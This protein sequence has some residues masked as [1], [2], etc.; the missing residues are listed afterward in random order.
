[1]TLFLHFSSIYHLHST[2]GTAQ[3]IVLKKNASPGGHVTKKRKHVVQKH[4]LASRIRVSDDKNFQTINKFQI[5][6]HEKQTKIT[7]EHENSRK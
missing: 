7:D 3:P 6:G 2:V 4:H 1:M 5:P